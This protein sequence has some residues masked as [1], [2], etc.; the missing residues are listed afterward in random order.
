[1]TDTI[2]L[3]GLVATRP[4]NLVTASGLAI[5]SFR[6]ASAQR[7]F[8][9]AESK[10]IV[11]D[12][13]WYTI[14]TFR[15]LAQ[16]VA[17]SLEKGDRVVVTGRLRIK[18]WTSGEK[19]GVTIE[20]DADG[21]GHDL[22]WGTSTWV[23]TNSV[24]ATGRAAGDEGGQPNGSADP[25]FPTGSGSSGEPDPSVDLDDDPESLSELESRFADAGAET[26]F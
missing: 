5:C 9:R 16:N 14:S 23:R 20:V 8:D 6:L 19:S 12:T 22:F 10:W 1:M 3:T 7:R 11:T 21:I 26:P 25:G 4:R 15:Q 2:T 24:A 18:E 13:N 17:G